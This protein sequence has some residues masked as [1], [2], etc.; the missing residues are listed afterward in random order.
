M[1]NVHNVRLS[2]LLA[3]LENAWFSTTDKPQEVASFIELVENV[4]GIIQSAAL[5]PGKSFLGQVTVPFHRP[6]LQIAY[7]CVRQARSL[8]RRN[9]ALNA[10]QR[11][12]INAMLEALLNLDIDAL[13]LVFDNAQGGLDADLDQDM[14]LL[15]AVFEQATRPELNSSTLLWLTRCQET[16]VIRTSPQLFARMDVVGFSDLA[17]LRAKKRPLYA[18]HVLIFHM[19]LAGIPS[20]AERLA[21]EGVVAAYANNAVSKAASSGLLEVVLPELPGEHNPAHNSYCTML[22]VVAGVTASLGRHG[23]FFVADVCGLVQL[24]SEQIHRA[25][26]WTI[27][28]TLTLPL[29]DEIE[30]TVALF[31]AIALASTASGADAGVARAEELFTADA[32]LLLQQLNYALTHHNHLASLFEPITAEERAAYAADGGSAPASSDMVDLVRR[33]FLARLV[34]RLFKISGAIV[35]ALVNISRGE[36]VLCKDPDEWPA[37]QAC[38]VPVSALHTG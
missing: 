11:L 15:A 36:D 23:Q 17:L 6:L 38:V 28:D 25:L 18:P 10:K 27:G 19:A 8:A 26:S 24:Y 33:P 5:P 2:L 34:H 29:L 9:K 22:S 31:S 30:Q 3:L 35:M 37:D 14:Q 20:A 1:A 16:D 32:L 21:S 4:K 7:F 13:R 12:T